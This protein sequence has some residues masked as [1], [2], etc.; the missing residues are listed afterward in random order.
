MSRYLSSLYRVNDCKMHLL[1][2]FRGVNGTDEVDFTR[3]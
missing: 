1:Q 2:P 3:R